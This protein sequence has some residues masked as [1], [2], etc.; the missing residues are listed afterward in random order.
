MS[1]EL[2]SRACIAGPE[3]CNLFIFHLPNEMTNWDMYNL[4]KRFGTILSVHIM[5][6][7]Q[8]GL[9]R[10]FGEQRTPY[11]KIRDKSANFAQVL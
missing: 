10:G 7:K 1:C 3:G 5:I 11:T 9:S 4:F 6:N 2:R 8:T